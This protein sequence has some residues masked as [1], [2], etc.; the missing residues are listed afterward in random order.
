MDIKNIRA[1]HRLHCNILNAKVDLSPTCL[2]RDIRCGLKSNIPICCIL[3]FIVRGWLYFLM[4]FSLVEKF[5][6]SYPSRTKWEC[7][8]IPCFICFLF[9]RVRKL[10]V[11]PQSDVNCCCFGKPAIVLLSEER[12][13]NE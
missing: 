5:I 3:F 11:C 12:Y 1:A 7:N 13:L 8:Y 2:F 10:Y 6:N 9:R 4:N